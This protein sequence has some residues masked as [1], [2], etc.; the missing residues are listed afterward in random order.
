LVHGLCEKCN[1]FRI[2]KIIFFEKNPPTWCLPSNK[3]C[4]T[5]KELFPSSHNFPSQLEV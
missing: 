5:G 1:I 4:G 2:I 3:I